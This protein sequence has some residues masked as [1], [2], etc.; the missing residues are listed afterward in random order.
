MSQK[1]FFLTSCL[2]TPRLYLINS[3]V[4][5][6]YIINVYLN[7]K[8]KNLDIQ[9]SQLW[10]EIYREAKVGRV[11]DQYTLTKRAKGVFF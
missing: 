4:N 5:G 1:R 2:E 8:K 7:E 9:M 11:K 10:R 6:I 3:H